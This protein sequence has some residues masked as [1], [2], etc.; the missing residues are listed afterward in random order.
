MSKTRE[1]HALDTVVG[2]TGRTYSP[3]DTVEAIDRHLVAITDQ[4]HVAAG[5][6]P[7]SCRSLRDDANALLERRLYL[8]TVDTAV[9]VTKPGKRR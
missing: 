8:E 5:R 4:I 6:A 9:E 1:Q 7:E 2:P 3:A